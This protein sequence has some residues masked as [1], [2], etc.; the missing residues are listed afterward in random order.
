MLRQWKRIGATGMLE[1]QTGEHSFTKIQQTE[2][3][4]SVSMIQLWLF[5]CRH[6]VHKRRRVR[7]NPNHSDWPTMGVSLSKL[8][9]LASRLGFK[10]EQIS[11]LQT[12]N[13]GQYMAQ[14]L[15]KSLCKEEFYEYEE[16]TV[17]S[18]SNKLQAFL[19]NLPEYEEE[20]GATAQLT[21]NDPKL[22]ASHRFNSPTKDECDRQRRY[23]F[24]NQIFGPDEPQS[25]YITSLGVTKDIISCF[26]DTALFQKIWNERQEI[27]LQRPD[28]L[29]PME[30]NVSGS[31][32]ELSEVHT[33]NSSPLGEVSLSSELDAIDEDERTLDLHNHLSGTPDRDAPPLAVG[34]EEISQPMETRNY[35]SIHRKV[36]DILSMWSQSGQE[37]ILVFLFESRTY[38]KFFLSG[39]ENLQ[40]I[41]RD[42][43][44]DHLLMVT[45][46]SDEHGLINLDMNAVYEA[47][48]K[49]RLVLAAKKDN[50]KQRRQVEGTI[51][52]VQ[53]KEYILEYNVHTGKRKADSVA[54]RSRKRHRGKTAFK[55]R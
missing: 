22:K 9:T 6:F 5:A 16:Y 51:S 52:L 12:Q 45:D 25:Q 39:G 54:N 44:K 13:L 36:P 14:G 24:L 55:R 23:M 30:V 40:T 28:R 50:P 18:M 7:K 21:T 43:A 27:C 4:F 15:L 1:I 32:D 47:A 38:Y 35:V 20:E 31:A 37:V 41:L 49:Q 11:F 46:N 2:H 8:A 19:Q 42:L 34:F 33:V 17:Q 48:L 53:L 26:F 10:S 3:S 29:Q